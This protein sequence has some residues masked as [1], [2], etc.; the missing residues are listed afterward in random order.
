MQAMESGWMIAVVEFAIAVQSIAARGSGAGGE[1]SNAG[2]C[3]R[4]CIL[5]GSI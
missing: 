3:T 1:T 2:R 5:Y 4:V